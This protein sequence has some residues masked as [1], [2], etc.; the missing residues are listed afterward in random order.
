ME[1]DGLCRS[2]YTL[3]EE[4]LW[5]VSSYTLGEGLGK[6]LAWEVS[7]YLWSVFSMECGGLCVRNFTL[8]QAKMNLLQ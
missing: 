1:V 3:G 4:V 8:N 2:G 5:G 6:G 7:S